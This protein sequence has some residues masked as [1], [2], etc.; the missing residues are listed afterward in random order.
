MPNFIFVG[1][2]SDI[3]KECENALASSN[4]FK[5]ARSN[6]DFNITDAGNF[7]EMEK[8][9]ATAKEKLDVIDGVV[10]FCGS[11]LLKPAHL[12]SFEEYS[13]VINSS[14]T[15]AFATVRAVAKNGFSNCSTVLISSAVAIIGVANHEAISAAKAGILGL[16]KSASATYANK[17]L[18]FNAILPSLIETKLTKKIT[19]NEES[20]K[21]SIALNGL[22]R[23]GTA[24]D[25]ANMIVF[26]LNPENSFITGSSFTV[27]GGLCNTKLRK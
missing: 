4:I 13:S 17:N 5:I 26:L 21:Y 25:V 3:S 11:L 23:I 8:A 14:L 22:N 15:S 2:N 19:Q 18:R 24:K 12:T 27:E 10:N 1:S 9:F 16:A 20:V 6:S 7:E